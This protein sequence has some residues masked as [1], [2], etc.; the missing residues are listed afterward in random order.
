MWLHVELIQETITLIRMKFVAVFE[1]ASQSRRRGL[2][3]LIA[4]KLNLQLCKSQKTSN[5]KA[6]FQAK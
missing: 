1:I 3:R 5:E 2:D 4:D 6:C